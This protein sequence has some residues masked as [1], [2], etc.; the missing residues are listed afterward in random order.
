MRSASSPRAVSMMTGIA[1]VAGSA[2]IASQTSSPS[3]PGSMMSRMTRSTRLARS[4]GITSR[5]EVR[6]STMWP[7]ARQVV[8]DEL[9]DVGVVFDDE[10]ARHGL[11]DD[12]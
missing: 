10:N 11:N 2:R 4:R 12:N 7:G 8:G 6:R 3:S 9:R 1:A 5:P